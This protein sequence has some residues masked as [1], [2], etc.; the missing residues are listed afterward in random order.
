M[1]HYGEI[2]ELSDIIDGLDNKWV[3]SLSD[4]QLIVSHLKKYKDILEGWYGDQQ[5]D[6][7]RDSEL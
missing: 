1:I 6:I 5:H 7:R 4:K 2:K 3:L